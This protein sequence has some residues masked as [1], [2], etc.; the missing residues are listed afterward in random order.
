MIFCVSELQLTDEQLHNLTLIEIEKLLQS[1][2]RSL[3]EFSSLPY[4]KGYILEQL[5]NRLIYDERNYDTATLKAEFEELFA[6]LTGISIFFQQ[7]YVINQ[8]IPFRFT[9]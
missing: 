5:G 8:L 9:Y 4:P 1:S 6:S 7:F 3:T 2:R